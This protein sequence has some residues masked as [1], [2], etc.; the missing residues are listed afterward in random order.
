[1]MLVMN[2]MFSYWT[3]IWVFFCIKAT[4]CKLTNINSPYKT[5]YWP[6]T[7]WLVQHS[8]I[9]IINMQHII[10]IKKNHSKS[11]SSCC[12]QINQFVNIW[13]S[14]ADKKNH[15]LKKKIM[16]TDKKHF[17]KK[18]IDFLHTQII[19]RKTCKHLCIL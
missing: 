2:K 5:R 13:Q 9:S 8:L 7:I 12:I 3:K 10:N 19:K 6:K 15:P 11:A 17:D 18:L 14:G 4:Y 16:I 1:M